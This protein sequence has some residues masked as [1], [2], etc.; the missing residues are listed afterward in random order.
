MR[1]SRKSVEGDTYNIRCLQKIE[2]SQV[3][4]LMRHPRI[5]L[6]RKHEQEARN[7]KKKKI[8]AKISGIEIKKKTTNCIK[9]TIF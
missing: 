1:C 5:Y 3:N 2:V 9:K 6:R 8:T 4:G 7:D